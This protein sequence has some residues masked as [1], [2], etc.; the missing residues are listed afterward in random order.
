[1]PAQIDKYCLLHLVMVDDRILS[2]V[3]SLSILVL[4]GH[5]VCEGKK[6]KVLYFEC[7]GS[8]TRHL[9]VSYV[10]ETNGVEKGDA[11]LVVLCL[12]LIHC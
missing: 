7:S 6:E 3:G 11:I 2:A 8:I 5:Q 1:M 10:V 4:D 9:A 12:S